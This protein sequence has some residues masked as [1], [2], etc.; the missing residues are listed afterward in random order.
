[1]NKLISVLALSMICGYAMAELRPLGS[2]NRIMCGHL[3]RSVQVCVSNVIGNSD[4][5]YLELNHFIAGSTFVPVTKKV[6]NPG[7]AGV[8][9]FLY[10][11]RL[12]EKN[13]DLGRGYFM[14][15]EVSLETMQIIVPGSAIKAEY[16]EK[17]GGETIYD[18][19]F[20]MQFVPQ[21]R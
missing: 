20:D 15:M 12:A 18:N 6:L 13:E 16:L 8:G 14:E 17:M 7:V 5:Y 2:I 10:K 1:M 19:S 9:H 21:T 11:G 3:N 4:R